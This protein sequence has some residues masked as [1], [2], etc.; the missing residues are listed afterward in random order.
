MIKKDFFED[1]IKKEY[2]VRPIYLIIFFIFCESLIALTSYVTSP[3]ARLHIEPNISS[4]SVSLKKGIV[5]NKIG[6]KDMFIKVTTDGKEGYVNKLFLSDK[7][8]SGKVSFRSDI[9]QSTSVKAR[10]RASNF[11]QTA[12]ARGFSESQTLR[13]R[14]GINDYD[15]D[16]IKWLESIKIDEKEI[17]K[18]NN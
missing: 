5:V 3:I 13:T 10:A 16:S 14:G 4:Q 12:A 11:T 17:E 2:E 6:E 1:I 18:F 9:D 8:T 15:M 7:P